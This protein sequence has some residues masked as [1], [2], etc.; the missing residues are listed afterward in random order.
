MS[1]QIYY[2][3][4]AIKMKKMSSIFRAS[5]YCSRIALCSTHTHSSLRRITFVDG[6][7]A[8]IQTRNYD[9]MQIS[10]VLM[11]DAKQRME[12]KSEKKMNNICQW[13]N[14]TR[15]RRSLHAFQF[16]VADDLV[17]VFCVLTIRMNVLFVFVGRI[18]TQ[19]PHTSRKTFSI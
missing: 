14:C 8:A 10:M 6:L 19:S 15:R 13:S 12:P 1:H 2:I 16:H 9:C 5:Y 18:S 4:C 11:A 17:K 7:P 3:I